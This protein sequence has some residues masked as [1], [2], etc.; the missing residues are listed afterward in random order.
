LKKKHLI[1][2]GAG[3]PHSGQDPAA[4]K[5]IFQ[6]FSTLNFILDFSKKM[7][8]KTTYVSGFKSVKIKKKFPNLQIIHNKEWNKTGPIFSLDKVPLKANEDIIIMYSDILV[9]FETFKNLAQSKKDFT[10]IIDSNY[11]KRYKYRDKINLYSKEKIFFKDNK[12]YFF[13]DKNY[14]NKSA[15]L[16]GLIK[17]DHS[18]IEYLKKIL[19]QINTRS[20]KCKLHH[21]LEK[22]RKKNSIKIVDIKGDWAE[23]NESNDIS[24]FILGTKSE[25]LNR[26]KSIIKKGKILDQF[27]FNV[28]QWKRNKSTI[29]SN[30]TTKFKS[31]PLIVRSSAI[32]EDGDNISNAGKYLSVLR[33]KG[34]KNIY[35][36]I[37]DVIRSFGSK[38]NKNE[39][40]VQTYLKNSKYVGVVTTKSK[41]TGSPW[42]IINF[43]KTD[44]TQI[45][46][47]GDSNK[48]K[49]LFLRRDIKYSELDKI[50]IKKLI[51][52][53]KELEIL[54]SN[55]S[56]DIEFAIDKKN[57]IYIFQVRPLFIK[58][59]TKKIENIIFEKYLKSENKYNNYKLDSKL[60]NSNNLIFGVMPDW[61][62]AEIIGFKPGNLSLSLYQKLI[63]EK[64]WAKQRYEFGYKN[65]KRKK[66]I[67]N[68]CGTPYVCVNKSI[69]S[70]IPKKLPNNLSKRI[71]TISLNNLI[72]SPN[73]HDK[74][75]FEIIPNCLDF[76]FKDWN[77]FYLKNGIKKKEL[78][79]FKNSLKDINQNAMDIYL[80]NSNNF[81]FYKNL[82]I[83]KYRSPYKKIKILM[84]ICV[85]KLTLMFAHFARCGFISV[86]IMKS[87]L[88]RKKIDKKNYNNFFNSINT[89]SKEFQNDVRLYKNKR[90][91]KNKIV[92]KYGH[93]RP[94]TYDIT[95]QR[96][97]ENLDL[98]L[99]DPG[100]KTPLNI[101]LNNKK[102]IFN[103]K[104]LK[105]LAKIGFR[106][107]QNNIIDFFFGSIEKR[108]SSK[109]LFTRYL[110]EILKLISK[111]LNK[112][113]LTN[114]DISMLSIYDIMNYFSNKINIHDLRNKIK[115]NHK[116]YCY[117]LMCDMPN[118][119]TSKKSFKQF[120][121]LLDEPNFVG[122]K[123][124]NS[125]I[126]KI[127]KLEDNK[128]LKNKIILIDSADPGFDWVFSHEITGL[129]TKFGG[130]NSHMAIRCAELNLPAAI[131]VGEKIFQNLLQSSKVYLD[132][133]NRI[134]KTI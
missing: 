116:N 110:S 56:L 80:K 130:T 126:I 11:K 86:I 118:I 45:I 90:L 71:F 98:F 79:K 76:N 134:L 9:R 14:S 81:K 83:P 21:L 18:K 120:E 119:I 41:G 12:N 20:N 94:G 113:K 104:F 59:Q 39:I 36:A 28:L 74:I 22:I 95:S 127:S 6:K 35:K 31:K 111:E 68:F 1:I 115:N 40:F 58:S 70:F 103:K 132:P 55:N 85:N 10:C 43:Q 15:E 133:K 128:V 125:K 7:N 107:H 16:L 2:L 67:E 48:I 131:G 123:K 44:D 99:K 34:K 62:P 69:E 93:L 64:N 112:M 50:F 3:K 117:D 27:K 30:I 102:L 51:S 49:T 75:E 8:L 19:A 87:A 129:I 89:I 97:D 108:E 42:Y 72:K 32:D 60:T 109:F 4:L 37:K 13:S 124:V 114:Q 54:L 25:T 26:L 66:L 91:S 63:T 100:L 17:I 46:T 65:I 61:N 82:K 121:L 52:S 96:Y 92:E 33:V 5:K 57:R 23:I 53:V 105:E 84:D 38:N 73:K 78:I 77:K 88:K 29:I 122:E 101:N 106:G 24:K 47:K